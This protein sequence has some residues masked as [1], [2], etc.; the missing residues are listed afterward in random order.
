MTIELLYQHHMSRS[1]GSL[2][3][4]DTASTAKKTKKKKKG[5]NSKKDDTDASNA[6]DDN[7]EIV[8]NTP[9]FAPVS[10]EELSP[11]LAEVTKR[12]TVLEGKI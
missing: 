3:D 4:E 1:G 7:G 8:K 11:S 2:G 12:T 5:K 10:W 6:D 9:L